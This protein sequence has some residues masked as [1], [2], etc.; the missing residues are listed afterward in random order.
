[1]AGSKAGILFICYFWFSGDGLE[2]KPTRNFMAVNLRLS[3]N[4]LY[5]LYAGSA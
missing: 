3:R 5:F 2:D 1:M 4:A